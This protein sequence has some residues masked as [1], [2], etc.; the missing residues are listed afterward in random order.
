MAPIVLTQC[1]HESFPAISVGHNP[2]NTFWDPSQLFEPGF[3][4]A[5]GA[6]FSREKKE[7]GENLPA[8]PKQFDQSYSWAVCQQ[9]F[10][11]WSSPDPPLALCVAAI[12]PEISPLSLIS[13]GLRQSKAA[14]SSAQAAH[15]VQPASVGEDY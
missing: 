4:S 1:H 6:I 8:L 5:F 12:E 13:H 3:S 9:L 2:L 7:F 10:P 14:L 15:F 11:G